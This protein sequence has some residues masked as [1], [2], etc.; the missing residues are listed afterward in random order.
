[1]IVLLTAPNVNTIAADLL[2]SYTK[3][4]FLHVFPPP[5]V[6]QKLSVDLVRRQTTRPLP[7]ATVSSYPSG[8]WAS[9]GRW[10]H[11]PNPNPNFSCTLSSMLSFYT[12]N[13]L[14]AGL[15]YTILRS[16]L[17]LFAR[18]SSDVFLS[19]VYTTSFFIFLGCI[20]WRFFRS[21]P[22]RCMYFY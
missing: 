17:G 10:C 4:F 1:M 19:I 22:L 18:S 15:T 5:P 6:I 3:I 20:D 21:K 2:Q 8:T 7:P 9:P 16:V 13:H 11:F 12:R 14:L